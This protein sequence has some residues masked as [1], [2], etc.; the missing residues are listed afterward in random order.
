MCES[1]DA[2]TVPA[3]WSADSVEDAVENVKTTALTLLRCH[4]A[5]AMAMGAVAQTSSVGH[6]DE[7]PD[8][9]SVNA[10][11]NDLLVPVFVLLLQSG[12][13]A[14]QASGQLAVRV[15]ALCSSPQEP[16]RLSGPARGRRRP[17]GTAPAGPSSGDDP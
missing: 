13:A 15:I 2:V 9:P 10:R 7:P 4:P 17:G 6:G 1:H 14:L 16:L 11:V 3:S 8:E 5:A 12:D